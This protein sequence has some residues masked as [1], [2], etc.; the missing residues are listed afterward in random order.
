VK[1]KRYQFPIKQKYGVVAFYLAFL[2]KC[3]GP[4][5]GCKLAFKDSKTYMDPSDGGYHVRANA[6]C[7]R[8]QGKCNMKY[9]FTVNRVPKPGDDVTVEVRYQMTFVN[10]NSIQK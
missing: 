4:M 1:N 7:T 5:K 10:M 2:E 6:L 3:T 8:W 9:S